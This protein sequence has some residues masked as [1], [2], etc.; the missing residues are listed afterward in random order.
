M[1]SLQ[2]AALAAWEVRKAEIAE[3]EAEK[4]IELGL[5]T[6]AALTRLG[7]HADLVDGTSA[8]ADGVRLRR[9]TDG[10]GWQVAGTC[11]DCGASGWSP[12]VNDLAGIGQY[13][14]EFRLDYGHACRGYGYSDRDMPNPSE[15]LLAALA[16]WLAGQQ[17]G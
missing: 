15:R 5:R 1:T 7:V 11:P 4:K 17:G 12:P 14:E 8:I 10:D 6:R 16:D 2:E 9:S 3:S 13:L